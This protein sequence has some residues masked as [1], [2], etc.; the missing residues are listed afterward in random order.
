MGWRRRGLTMSLRVRGMADLIIET[1]VCRCCY[2]FVV[3]RYKVGSSI[4]CYRSQT[5]SNSSSYGMVVCARGPATVLDPESALVVVC[6]RAKA[7]VCEL[8]DIHSASTRQFMSLKVSVYTYSIGSDSPVGRM[9]QSYRYSPSAERSDKSI[10]WEFTS[11]H[12]LTSIKLVIAAG[13]NVSSM[14]Q[15]AY[16]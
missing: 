3:Y 7:I 2:D 1:N 11:T 10:E 5:R 16:G 4:P 14:H 9:R 15:W 12:A 8:T 6:S 13:N